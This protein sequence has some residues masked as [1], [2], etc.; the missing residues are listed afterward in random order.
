MAGNKKIIVIQPNAALMEQAAAALS[1]AGW[2]VSGF[3]RVCHAIDA[4]KTGD[5]DGVVVPI[6][7]KW[8][9]APGL[10]LGLARFVPQAKLTAWFDE[11]HEK[12]ADL[13]AGN[14][15][16]WVTK[17]ADLPKALDEA[18]THEPVATPQAE[19]IDALVLIEAESSLKAPGVFNE[20]IDRGIAAWALKHATW[21][22]AARVHGPDKAS[23]EKA[24][25]ELDELTDVVKTSNVI[26]TLQPCGF[27]QA[28]LYAKREIV[29]PISFAFA[30]VDFAPDTAN[31]TSK[32]ALAPQV[33]AL[34]TNGTQALV[35]VAG[36][37]L[38][39]IRER[40]AAGLYAQPD[41]QG[42]DLFTGLNILDVE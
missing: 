37:S 31:I 27:D 28:L 29:N 6:G 8:F 2:E 35:Q 9:D 25:Q 36:P 32:L 30:L 21:H 33:T 19:G 7:P 38:T 20:L 40:L 5:F 26:G 3:H 18:G 10:L 1:K 23:I 17:A 14:G 39:I 12:T 42:I 34:V 4:M 16:A 24:I 41:V 13:L 22:M 15:I 11:V